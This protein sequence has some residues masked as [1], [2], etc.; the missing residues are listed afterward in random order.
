M[1]LSAFRR[2]GAHF[3]SLGAHFEENSE[4]YDFED[5]SGVKNKV[6][7]ETLFR[8]FLLFFAFCVSVFFCMNS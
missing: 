3:G 8:H 6:I 5:A 2:P 1:I 7:F 4:F